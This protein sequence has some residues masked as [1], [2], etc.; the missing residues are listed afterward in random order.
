MYY[1]F[2]DWLIDGV[3][4]WLTIRIEEEKEEE[5]CNCYTPLTF[6]KIIDKGLLISVNISD[7]KFFTCKEIYST[8][9]SCYLVC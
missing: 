2:I 4:E 7:L 3:S 5:M 8:I 9:V 6:S 1:L